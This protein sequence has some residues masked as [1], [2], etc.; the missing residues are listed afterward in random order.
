MKNDEN[1]INVNRDFW[2]L[3][4]IRPGPFVWQ[5]GGLPHSHSFD[6]ECSENKVPA[7]QTLVLYTS[8]LTMQ[9]V[10]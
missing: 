4:R 2:V 7:L 8:D 3:L 9:H 1:K 6:W 5:V 10:R